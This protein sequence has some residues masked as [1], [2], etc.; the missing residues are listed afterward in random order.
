[1]RRKLI[2]GNWKMFGSQGFVLQW[3]EDFSNQTRPINC[4]FV[5]FPPFPYLGVMGRLCRDKVIMLGAQNCATHLEGAYTGEVSARMLQDLGCRYVLIGHSERRQLYHERNADL[6][7][8]LDCAQEA[9]LIP[10][11]CVGETEQD[12]TAGKTFDVLQQQ[13][14][15]I[16]KYPSLELVLAYEPV[17]AI[18]TGK[19]ASPDQVQEV[20]YYLR[21]ALGKV[22][23]TWSE[24]TPILYGGS[25]KPQNAHSLLSLRDVDGALVGGASLKARDWIDI[26]RLG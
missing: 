23:V 25:V 11:F 26:A 1:M 7:R 17:W 5:V 2:M 19:V 8:K 15:C 20:H 14:D 16:L 3:L 13:L 9:G 21:Q 12:R 4:D 10:V 6:E 18:G 22:N 24:N